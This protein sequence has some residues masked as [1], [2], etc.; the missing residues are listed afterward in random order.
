LREACHTSVDG[1][2]IDTLE[3][4]AKTLGLD[5]AQMMMPVEHV[6]L[7]EAEALPALVWSGCP[8]A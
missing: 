7:R 4:L 8:R 2:S 5:A 3:E 6:L 1:S